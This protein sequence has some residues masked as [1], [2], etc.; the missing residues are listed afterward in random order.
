LWENKGGYAWIRV[1]AK[2]VEHDF[3][4]PHKDV[5]YIAIPYKVP[6]E[7]LAQLAEFDGSAEVLRIK[8]LVVA[9]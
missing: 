6:F 1:N 3:P 8:G 4:I 9:G 5:L 2:E 7:K